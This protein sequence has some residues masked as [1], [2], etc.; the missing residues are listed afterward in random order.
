[1]TPRKVQ[2]V[3]RSYSGEKQNLFGPFK[4]AAEAAEWALGNL[5]YGGQRWLIEPIWELDD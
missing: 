5:P 3:V 1:M 4:T 2:Y